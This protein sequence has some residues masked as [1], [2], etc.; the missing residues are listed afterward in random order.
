MKED[1]FLYLDELDS[2]LNE[3]FSSI[4][5]AFMSDEFVEQAV[6]ALDVIPNNVSE[7]TQAE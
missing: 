3:T 4:E 7:D 5:S 6:K 2:L 1:I